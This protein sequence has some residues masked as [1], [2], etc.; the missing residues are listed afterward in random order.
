[1][2]GCPNK[3]Y[4]TL[5]HKLRNRFS[6]KDEEMFHQQFKTY[7]KKPEQTWEDPTQEIEVLSI[8]ACRGME[9][10]KRDSMAAKAF[11]EAVTDKQVRRTIPRQ[12]MMLS[13]MPG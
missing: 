5:V 8:K 13:S 1:M 4:S 7:R 12:S 3:R 10:T 11:M 6:P 2:S 9:E